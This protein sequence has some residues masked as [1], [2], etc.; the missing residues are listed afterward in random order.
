VLA[1][2]ADLGQVRKLA[3][4]VQAATDRLDVFVSNAGIGSGEPDGDR[5]RGF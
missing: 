3:A 5:R 1:D 4:D 2:L